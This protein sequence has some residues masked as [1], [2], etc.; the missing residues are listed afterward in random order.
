MS[1][2]EH[3][4][5]YEDIPQC[6]S[7]DRHTSCEFLYLREGSIDLHCGE[8]VYHIN[9]SMI[10]LIPSGVMHL[11]ELKRH[12]I[13]KR[14]L[15]FVNPWSYCGIYF[16]PMPCDILM[17][18]SVMKPLV[19]KDDFGCVGLLRKLKC[20]LDKNDPL[21]DDM[22]M[23]I[24]TEI[25]VNIARQNPDMFA[26][27]EKPNF[28]VAQARKYLLDHC[29]EPVKISE[30]ADRFYINKYYFSHIFREQAGMSPRQF[31]TFCRVSKAYNL[32]LETDMQLT[33][34]SQICGFSSPSD[35]SKKFRERFGVSP[36]EMR[37]KTSNI[38]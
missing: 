36:S 15:V 16:S 11:P 4:C 8:D 27:K 34:I 6:F 14:T 21:C 17:G 28:I 13:Y 25:L 31:L 1:I 35:L 2:I 32:L 10:Y 24:V 19:A 37:K 22:V 9:D 7:E 29:T 12:D 30:L 33:E 38:Q 20:E 3:F 18:V 23:S 26:L 5:E